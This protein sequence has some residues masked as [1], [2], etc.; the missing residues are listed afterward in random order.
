[1]R[2]VIAVPGLVVVLLLSCCAPLFASPFSGG[3]GTQADPYQIGGIGDW[4]TLMNQTDYWTGYYFVVTAD[5]DFSGATLTPVGSALGAGAFRGSVDGQGHVVRNAIINLPS[6]QCVG[7]F[8]V[9]GPSA[10]ISNLGVE[11]VAV[12]ARAYAGG[13]CG[14]NSGSISGCYADSSV[15]GTTQYCFGGLCG[16]NES[17]GTISNSYAAGTVTGSGLSDIGGLCGSNLSGG[18]ITRCY[19][20]ATASGARRVGGLCGFNYGNVSGC[21]ATGSVAG[22]NNPYYL[23]GLCGLN[24]GRISDCYAICTVTADA[25]YYWYECIGGL[26][27]RNEGGGTISGCWAAGPV[28]GGDDCDSI[29]GLCGEN[30]GGDI[31]DCWAAGAVTGGARSDDL[32]GLCGDNF[33]TISNCCATGLVTDEAESYYL[34]GL[35]GHNWGTIRDC[36]ATGAVTGPNA[37]KVGGLVGLNQGGA[38]ERCYSTGKPRGYFQ[39]GGLCGTDW[40]GVDT[41]N[42]WDTETSEI[43]QSAMGM[44]RTTA[45]MQTQSTFTPPAADWDFANTW[46]MPAN[47]YPRLRHLSPTIATV[48]L[49][50]GTK[51]FSYNQHLAASGGWS[52]YTW[53]L[54]S[55]A[56]PAGLSLQAS[57]GSITGTPM[58]AGTF[59][60]TVMVTDVFTGGLAATATKALSI[61]IAP[62][63][64]DW[65]RVDK[66]ILGLPRRRGKTRSCFKARTTRGLTSA[67]LRTWRSRSAISR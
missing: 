66:F 18:T 19:A 41:N 42:F 16:C 24:G 49:P 53:T 39:V 15:T 11:N 37:D 20:T 48:S 26:C 10:R 50:H 22:S 34:G 2:S 44:G 25:D 40:P 64:A 7:L 36:Y 9:L 1:M 58:T 38:V 3:N 31:R 56:L 13:L 33:G 8:G 60:F 21:W 47:D 30:G 45:E 43:D 27:G 32:G 61:A 67:P 51:G 59:S 65:L 29:G 6:E 14:D 28:T 63:P 35:C 12:T 55:G 52:P 54:E 57:L 62:A 17:G 46:Y 5:L 4:Q 23:G